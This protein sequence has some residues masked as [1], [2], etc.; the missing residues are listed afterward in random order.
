MKTKL[1][2]PVILLASVMVSG[3]TIDHS[4]LD[5]W[6]QIGMLKVDY[7][8]DHDVLPITYR[9]GHF[10][11]VKIVVKGGA[12]NMHKCMIYFE[13]GGQQDV[14]LRHNFAK[15]SESRVIDLKGNKRFIE[16]IEFWYDTKN[17]ADRKALIVVWG[18]K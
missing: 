7:G 12:L 8:L 3:F 15:G 10:E 2:L 9:Q 17:S 5:P 13:K 18:R 6:V 1:T 4:I 14:P 11:A 16:R